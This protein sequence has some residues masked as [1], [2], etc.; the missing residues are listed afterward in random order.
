MKTFPSLLYIGALFSFYPSYATEIPSRAQEIS[1]ISIAPSLLGKS[2][3]NAT[4]PEKDWEE[5]FSFLEK[6]IERVAQGKF[7]LKRLL[8]E[9]LRPESVY[10]LEDKT[11]QD[12][13]LR[14]THALLEHLRKQSLKNDPLNEGEVKL[15]QWETQ[16]WRN[17]PKNREE[18]LHA[19]KEL[20]RIRRAISFTNPLLNFDKITFLTHFGQRQAKGEV[21]IVDQYL[22]FNARP[23]GEPYIL[24]NPFSDNPTAQP[25]LQNT[26]LANGS[27]KGEKLETGSFISLE[28]SYDA[29]KLYFAWTQA[30]STPMVDKP[31]LWEG[32]QATLNDIKQRPASYHHYFW[33]P[34]RVYQ[35]YS[36]DLEKGNLNQ[37]TEGNYNNY[38][39]CELPSGRL[40]YISE[41]VGG[42]QRC[43][44]RWISSGTLHSMKADGSDQFPISWHETNEWQ[45]SVTNEGYIAYTRWDYV[46][47]DNIGA[48]HLWTC[49]PDGRDPRSPHGNYALAREHRP[50]AEFSFRA[51]PKSR[52][53]VAIATAHHGVCYGSLILVDPSV[54]DDKMMS[55][56]KRITPEALFSESEIE[57]GYPYPIGQASCNFVAEYYGTPWPLSEDFYL[58]VYARDRAN[59]GIYLVDSFGNRELIWKDSKVPCLDPIPLQARAKPPVIPE[60]TTQSIDNRPDNTSAPEEGK[61]VIL[62]VYDTETPLPKDTKAKWIRVVNIFPKSTTYAD[63]PNIGA[64]QESLARGSLGIAPVYEDGSACFNM[65]VGTNVYFQL[66]DE[67]K[68]A[69]HSMRS[70]TYIHA[71]ETLSC[72]GCHENKSAAPVNSGGNTPMALK[73]KPSPLQVE[74]TGSYPLSF[75]RLVQPVLDKNCVSCH[76]KKPKA[77]PLDGNTFHLVKNKDGVEEKQSVPHGWSNAFNS[78]HRMGWTRHGGNQNHLSD[79]KYSFSIA[80]DVGA[81]ASQLLPF[82]LK[83]HHDVKLNTEELQRITLWMDLNTNFFGDYKDTEQ[84]ATGKL[85]WPIIGMPKSL[86]KKIKNQTP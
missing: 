50:N 49:Y 85:V 65:P 84:Q 70:S 57:P 62:N 47:R 31:E 10:T 8:K 36:L 83:G 6:E 43:G 30:I 74:P 78:L 41:S 5:E 44:A 56:V 39:P 28:L 54:P 17:P 22:G 63:Y 11:P 16:Q 45:P 9:S 69:I 73:N 80:G 75:P 3:N 19:F 66:L 64:G 48:H 32:Q 35:I 51:I 27:R 20:C 46:D 26:S 38:D 33:A 77:P 25:L 37:L 67:N 86:P 53:L 21:H 12:I 71:G 18:Q 68:Q 14:R 34:D 42:N 55:Q 58:C 15:L 2:Q 79:N 29:K 1:P 40:A 59:Y 7:H 60:M 13:I 82:L 72:I 61:V 4:T 23:E 76:A 81:K 24:N 52:K